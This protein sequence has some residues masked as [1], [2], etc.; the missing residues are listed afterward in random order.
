MSQIKA[1]LIC[2]IIR[3]SQTNLLGKKETAAVKGR[4]CDEQSVLEWIMNNAAEYRS[5]F[6]ARLEN[7]TMTQLGEILKALTESSQDLTEILETVP[8]YP[9]KKADCCS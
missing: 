9:K 1:D 3:R 5:S 6:M 4:E 8:A 7:Y 2:E